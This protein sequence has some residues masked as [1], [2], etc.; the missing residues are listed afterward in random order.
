[1][2]KLLTNLSTLSDNRESKKCTHIMSEV[3]FMSIC[4]ILC[5]ADDWNSIRQFCETREHWFRKHLTLPGGIPVAITFNRIYAGL[6]PAEFRQLFIDWVRDVK[7]G[8]NLTDSDT[9]VVAIDGKTVKGSAWN[10]GK[11]AIH[12]V[13]AWCTEAGLS[14]GQF[15]VDSKSNEITAIPEL[16][17]LLELSGSLVTIDAMGCQKTIAACILERKADYLLAVKANQKTLHT[18]IKT[19]FDHYWTSTTEDSLGSGFSTVEESLHGR[20]DHRRCWV[21]HDVKTFPVAA[22]WGARTLAAVQLDSCRQGR[23]KTLIRYFISSRVLT[24]DQVLRAVRKHWRVE[25]QLHWVLDVAFDEDRCRARDGYA[26]EN[27][28]AARQIT[29][30]LLKLDTSVKLGIKNKRKACGWDEN[31]MLKVLGLI[32]L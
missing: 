5:G 16:L 20:R 13:N 25:N 15:K 22:T 14:M 4:A 30:N 24:A 17:R 28:A 7:S 6:D 2:N 29:L 27:L 3:M 23:G 32:D 10:K 19:L 8:L 18:E 12:M 1:M 21:N 11:D 26:A 31:Y 9:P